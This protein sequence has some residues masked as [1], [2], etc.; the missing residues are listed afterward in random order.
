MFSFN[1][2]KTENVNICVQK[3]GNVSSGQRGIALNVFISL[4]DMVTH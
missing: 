2:S 4:V 1:Y 3:M